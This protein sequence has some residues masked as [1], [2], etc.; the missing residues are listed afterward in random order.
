MRGVRRQR[1]IDVLCLLVIILMELRA[2]IIDTLV[3]KKKKKHI[4]SICFLAG[5]CRKILC[6][7]SK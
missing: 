4:S 5:K 1:G 2:N 6:N 3:S 7:L